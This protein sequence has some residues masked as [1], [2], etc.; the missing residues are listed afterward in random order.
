MIQPSNLISKA[1][2]VIQPGIL[3]LL[4]DAGRF[5][6]HS[7]GLTN[8]GPLDKISF[9]WANRL[10]DN[11]PNDCVIEASIGGL[12]LQV[13]I[14]TQIAVT[15]G[16]AELS[17]NQTPVASW[18][19]HSVKVGDKITFG[20]ATTTTRHYLA[21]KGG[22][23]VEP[24]FGSCATVAREK[25]GGLNGSA[26]KAGDEIPGL[27]VFQVEPMFGSCATVA[28]EKL[29]GLNGSAL[30]AGDALPGL[31][32]SQDTITQNSV[33]QSDRPD[34]LSSAK[35][36]DITLRVILGYQKDS[37]SNLQKAR[38]FNNEFTISD[39]CDRMG[40][41]LTGPEIKSDISSMLSEGICYGAI[42]VPADGQP[43][44]LLNDRQTIGGYP[45][46][47]SVLSLDIPKLTQRLPGTSVHFES[48]TMDDAQC[49]LH[50][51]H[52][53]Y[54][55]TVLRTLR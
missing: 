52:Y 28:R 53:R 38:F 32:V 23:Q 18:Q 41:R 15:G 26:L 7:I 5:G 55:N 44:I 14:D 20:F 36:N 22:F 19:T 12:V 11:S 51:A 2:T 29:G 4:Q 21:V 34:Y 24:M 8:G 9:D 13:E 39:K 25:L 46:I 37:F 35:S 31:S 48:M 10:L 43:I 33:N 3:S 27:S 54:Q 47:G 1:F 50:L 42:Q 40:F 6:K 45:K 30:K 16:D 17:I 49:E